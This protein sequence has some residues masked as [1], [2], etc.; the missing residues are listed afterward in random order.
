MGRTGSKTARGASGF[1][2]RAGRALDVPR[3]RIRARDP[4]SETSLQA[5]LVRSRLGGDPAA[6]GGGDL[7]PRLR[8]DSSVSER[9]IPYPVF[10]FARVGRLVLLLGRARSGRGE[11][12]RVPRTGHEGLLAA[13]A[14]AARRRAARADRPCHLTR[15]RS[16]L[17]GRLRR[18]ADRRD[19]L[20]AVW[21]AAV[22]I[23]TF[24]PGSGSPRSTSSIATCATPR[25]PDPALVLREPDCLSRL[26]GR[27]WLALPL[28][29]QPARGLLE[30]FRWSLSTGRRP[31]PEALVS[32]ATVTC[33]SSSAGSSYFRRVE[34]SLPTDLMSARDRGARAG[35]TLPAR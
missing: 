33:W 4:R 14:R 30:G 3:A 20:V 6:H 32:L 35:Q 34:R 15:S 18:R 17:H 16:G 25:L 2:A 9:G 8:A 31:G 5:D 26:V 13:A 1:V 11:P 23:V 29:A 10:V 7:H 19:P 28:L 24:G 27:G 22:L 21:L 12:R